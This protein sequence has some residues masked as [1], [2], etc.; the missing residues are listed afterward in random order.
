V[1]VA[2]IALSSTFNSHVL[3]VHVSSPTF[4]GKVYLLCSGTGRRGGRACRILHSV[5]P[6]HHHHHKPVAIFRRVRSELMAHAQA[7]GM[8]DVDRILAMCQDVPIE[9]GREPHL[10]VPKDSP[11]VA[12]VNKFRQQWNITPNDVKQAEGSWIMTKR[13]ALFAASVLRRISEKIGH[14]FYDLSAFKLHLRSA[15]DEA[16]A[17][18]VFV[19]SETS[20]LVELGVV[21]NYRF[22]NP[23]SLLLAEK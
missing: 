4:Q 8:V 6:G 16:S 21:I 2:E 1:T 3:P 14:H 23:R 7:F 11:I 12:I 20:V 19:G 17:S 15:A 22:E 5:P 18:S 13:I 10:M 9:A